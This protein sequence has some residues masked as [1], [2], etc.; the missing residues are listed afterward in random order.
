M[1]RAKELWTL[2]NDA[3]AIKA[4]RE[5]PA[6]N[7]HK[8]GG[9]DNHGFGTARQFGTASPR[10]TASPRP[11]ASDN[12]AATSSR[13][14]TDAAAAAAERG[15]QG[16]ALAGTASAPETAPAAAVPAARAKPKLSS[17]QVRS[18]AC[19]IPHLPRCWPWRRGGTSVPCT[20]GAAGVPLPLCA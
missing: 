5:K 4:E 12:G 6:K 14:D 9:M 1:C 8:Y 3:D 10:Q 13:G 11:T 15:I 19:C 20:D 17:I 2:V 7:K 18:Q 16:L